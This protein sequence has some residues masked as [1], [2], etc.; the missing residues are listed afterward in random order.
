MEPVFC[1][2]KGG[3]TGQIEF[4]KRNATK[5][6]FLIILQ[7]FR[8][9]NFSNIFPKVY[10]EIF[11]EAFSWPSD[12]IIGLSF[13]KFQLFQNTHRKHFSWSLYLLKS[14]IL[15]CRAVALEKKGQF[16]KDFFWIFEI[17]ELSFL[18]TSRM[19]QSGCSFVDYLRATLLHTPLDMFFFDNF[20]KC[21]VL[22]FQKI[23]MKSYVMELSRVLGC[24]LQTC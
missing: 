8:N 17:L 1:I 11:F 23:L 7:N 4:F 2:V 10:E 22:L 21:S 15:D 9:S 16:R 3:W 12:V 14:E 6:V 18:S 19:Y 24:R 5:E 20:S 13:A